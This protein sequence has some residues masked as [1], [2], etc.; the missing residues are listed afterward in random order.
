MNALNEEKK[1]VKKEDIIIK[2]KVNKV[3]MNIN[4]KMCPGKKI[5]KDNKNNDDIE[6]F[7]KLK[8]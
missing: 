2:R 8:I 7:E 5:L 6:M 3:E 4:E 1:L